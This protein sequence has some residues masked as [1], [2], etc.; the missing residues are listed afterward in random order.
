M[1]IRPLFHHQVPKDFRDRLTSTASATVALWAVVHAPRSPALSFGRGLPWAIALAHALHVYREAQAAKPSRSVLDAVAST[2]FLLVLEC[3]HYGQEKEFSGDKLFSVFSVWLS[4]LLLVIFLSTLRGNS[5]FHDGLLVDRQHTASYLEVLTFLWPRKV[6]RLNVLSQEDIGNLPTLS[7]NCRTAILVE[8]HRRIAR[9]LASH[10]LVFVLAREYIKPLMFQ[11]SLAIIH[12]L[13]LLGPNL[14]TYHLLQHLSGGSVGGSHDSLSL[15]FLLGFSKALPALLGAWMDWVGSSMIYLPMRSTLLALIYQK[16]LSLPTV[17]VSVDGRGLQS[18]E[19]WLQASALSIR[20]C[21]WISTCGVVV[22]LLTQSGCTAAVLITLVG[23]KQEELQGY[24]KIAWLLFWKGFVE[25]IRLAILSGI[26][27][28]IYAWQGHS[29]TPSVAF[30][31]VNLFKELQSKLWDISQ[32]FPPLQAG[33]I[34]ASELDMF[35]E[36]SEIYEPQ[37]ISS[38]T[39][40]LHN[41]T[42]TRYGTASEGEKF[43]LE[44]VNAAFPTG[45]LSIISGKTGCGKSLLLSA[46]AGEAKISSGHI[47]RPFASKTEYSEKELDKNWVQPDTCAIVSQ[48]PWMDNSTIQDNILF[49]LPLDE[50]RYARVTVV[51]IK[52]VSLS[53]GQRSRIALARALYSRASFLL[54]DDVL[55]AV[56]TE[57]REWIV[58]KALCGNLAR[59]RTRILVTHHEKQLASKISYR[60]RIHDQTATGERLSS[61]AASS[62]E[63][64]SGKSSS[65]DDGFDCALYCRKS[66]N[67]SVKVTPQA[68]KPNQW[69]GSKLA[70]RFCFSDSMRME[71]AIDVFAVPKL[72]LWERGWRC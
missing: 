12:V 4:A 42:I 20:A 52:G 56:D 17:A 70:V 36:K 25:N 8:R 19:T 2:A 11:C 23:W 32:K 51:S 53:G 16:I 43:R 26:P 55:S 38:D 28:Y 3:M 54:M 69:W 40:S 66:G 58:E 35:L 30:A 21:H 57:V 50:E 27:I 48:N 5:E 22:G 67:S 71:Q 31:F 44:N 65:A 6:F 15:V 1:L 9:K 68:A 41:A 60:L 29:L 24:T 34:S 63:K 61:N 47:G 7:A 14:V 62:T 59:G 49:G 72:G 10:K 39:L 33:W 64:D 18:N 37:F 13:S 45:E 46:L